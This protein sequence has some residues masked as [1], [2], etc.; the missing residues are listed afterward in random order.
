[1]EER[2]LGLSSDDG[3]HARQPNMRLESRPSLFP[4][5]HNIFGGKMRYLVTGGSR[6]DPQIGRD[7]HS[8]GI[9]I[10]QAYGL[11]ETSAAAFATSP[12]DNLIGSVG[13]ALEGVE[14]KIID[15]Q[16]QEDGGQPVG[17]IA[18]R[19]AVVMRGYWKRP[20]ATAAAIRDGW[21]HTGDPG[22][23]DP[24]GNLF[25]TG[26][27]KKSSSSATEKYLSRRS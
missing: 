15:P 9:D 10:L 13:K 20:D 12:D 17:E 7:F 6:F 27:K 1:M 2:Q 5:I 19:G 8:L 22:Y 25:I 14:G 26:R 18:I 16:P 4:K 3:V 23:F 24:A 11:T 21:L